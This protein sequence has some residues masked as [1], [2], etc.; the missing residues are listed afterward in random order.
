MQDHPPKKQL[1]KILSIYDYGRETYLSKCFVSSIQWP[2]RWQAIN[3]K[4][5]GWLKQLIKKNMAVSLNTKENIGSK[6][7]N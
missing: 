7:S 4:H 6:G 5:Y 3:M 1:M 2:V